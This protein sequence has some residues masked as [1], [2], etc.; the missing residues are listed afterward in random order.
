MH[1]FR[2]AVRSL[3]KTPIVTAIAVL[4]V[5]LGIGANVAI[6]SIFN[7]M[8]LRPL[9]VHE[10]E[11]LVNFVSP[12]PRNGSISCGQA[13]TCDAIF[14]YPMFRDLERV[15]TVFTGIA[16]HR[17]FGANIAYGGVSEGGDG[18]LVSGSYFPVL[19]LTPYLGRLLNHDD[20]R[21]PGTGRVVVL[22]YDYWRR[23]F[24]ERADVIDQS[25]LVN[26]QALVIVGVAPRGFHGTT[27]GG[28]PVMYVPIS[29][30]EAIVPRWKG[31][32]NRRSYWAYLFARLKPAIE[33]EAARATFNT[34]YRSILAQ[35]DVPIQQG[36]RPSMLAQ[37]R[38]MQMQLESG[39][40]GQSRAPQEA[41]QPLTLLFGV[42][43]I[44]L[45]ICC[46]NV[47][48]LL[49]GRAAARSTEIAV[50]LSIGAGRR[51]I[52]GQLLVESM[53]LG[54]LG[55][56]GGLFV[57]RWTLTAMAAVMP[58]G[59]AETISMDLDGEMFAFAAALSL[60]TGLLFG[61][62]PALHSTRPNLVAALK[63][64]AGQPS[65]AKGAA[66]FRV[67]L[68]TA[69]IALSMAL[70]VS[71]GLFTKSLLNISRVD[72]GLDTDKIV[73]F[74]VSPA[75]NGHSVVRTRQILETIED[76]LSGIP[77][78]S[79][80]ATARVRLISGDA[81]MSGFQLQGIVE[82]SDADTSA[83]YNYVSP[84]FLRTLGVPLLAGREFTLADMEGA[85]KVAIVNEA[86]LKKF[87]LGRDAVGKRMNRSGRGTAFDIEIVGVSRDSAYDEVKEKAQPLVLMPYRQDPDVAGAHFYVRT[88]VS[89]QDLLAAIPR[90]IRDIDPTLPVAN[91]RTMTAQVN[92]N[93]SLDRFVTV[94]S[95]VFASLATLLAA[96][97]LYG[98]LAYTV[99]Q[100][101][102]EFGLRMALGANATTVR[103]LVLRQVGLMTCIG[104]A[105]GLASALAIS[106]TAESLL[107]QMSARDP[108][109]FA[110]ATVLLTAVALCAGVIPARRAAR[111]DPMT[112]LRYE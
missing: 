84:D 35:A 87:K 11:R 110:V 42:T 44:V 38:D 4:S 108:I 5:A 109:V 112:A 100:R 36:M 103:R 43:A 13:G 14:S 8:L 82:G 20:D 59:A 46:A 93:V 33:V 52:I 40:R 97:G 60:A 75:M 106:R 45:L 63:A 49:L 50:R 29:M 88:R 34:Q 51:H 12:G 58:G 68:A 69:Q 90:L 65:G 86:F 80:V 18:A 27:L 76:G 111:V 89:E 9:P 56:I 15:Q 99:T 24:G 30:R 6:F 61:L 55:G 67:T 10:P 32:D 92:T 102:R 37:F 91:L 41:R 3:L 77:G 74:G 62:F 105:I 72:L 31:L 7:S 94:M 64:N 95:A 28:R 2:F 25:I 66:R 70:L 26:G 57:A 16:A 101:T 78:V 85:P 73:V 104:A 81:S 19:G 23:R 54:A 47:A 53:L 71:A 107:F 17:D 96:L 83:F 39:A 1:E 98:V 48:N 21:E 22:S 79:G